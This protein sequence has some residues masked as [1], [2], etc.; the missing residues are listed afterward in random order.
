MEIL[1]RSYQQKFEKFVCQIYLPNTDLTEI[2]D[3]RHKLFIRGNKDPDKL[4]PT[5]DALQQHIK[6]A[7]Y[8]AR[9]WKSAYEAKPD[10]PSPIGNGWWL[11]GEPSQLQ[12]LLMTK[13]G[14]P[15][16]C[17]QLLSCSC[18]SCS[19]AKCGCRSTGV[20]CTAACSCFG[21]ECC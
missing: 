4:P 5:K 7:H 13:V 8:Q 6:R 19:T 18:K 16:V 15:K 14:I 21:A 17:T 11:G 10:L 9:V 20:G 3:V 2:N 12:P 1:Q